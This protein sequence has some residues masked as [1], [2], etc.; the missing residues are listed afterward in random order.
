MASE[1]V[2]QLDRRVLGQ[3]EA[4]SGGADNTVSTGSPRVDP[5]IRALHVYVDVRDAGYL[6]Q[7][8]ADASLVILSGSEMPTFGAR[9]AADAG[10]SFPEDPRR[11]DVARFLTTVLIT[12]IVDS[13]R[14]V[15]RVGDRRW[16]ELLAD[17]YCECRAHI[18]DGGGELVNTTGD[19]I[20]A[21]FNSP[22]R[23]IRAATAIQAVAR[24]SGMAVR[25]GL[26][27]GECERL[28]DGLTGV[29][30]HIAARI[31]ALA[32]GDAVMTTGTVRDL[33]T[34]SLLAFEPRGRRELRGVPG[35][36]TVFTVSDPAERAQG[37]GAASKPRACRLAGGRR[38]QLPRHA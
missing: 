7:R 8:V 33:V 37:R 27:T 17:H 25:A 1:Q 14:T 34:G 2:M 4:D 9:A 18:D 24:E 31:C 19:G 36:W 6:A 35:D 29:T 11:R 20:V 22:T 38:R 15:A 16:R 12:D 13:T 28:G 23:A 30:V 32:G 10:L 5:E 26:H 3:S 21:T